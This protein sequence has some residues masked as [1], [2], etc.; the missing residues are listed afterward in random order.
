MIRMC[1]VGCGNMG[2]HHFRRYMTLAQEQEPVRLVGVCDL[3]RRR[4]DAALADAPD[5]LRDIRFYDDFAEMMAKEAPDAVDICLPDSLQ[6][7]RYYTP[8]GLG[9]EANLAARLRAVRDW[10]EGRTDTPP[11]STAAYTGKGQ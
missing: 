8:T 6:G 10:R 2:S 5:G 4:F 11:F 3:E 1:L 7:R 9:R